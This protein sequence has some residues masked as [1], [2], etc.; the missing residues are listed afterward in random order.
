M[1][2][3]DARVLILGGGGL[4]T[5]LA[6]F[7]ARAGVDVTLFVKP[8]QAAGFEKP[9]V[10]IAGLAEFTA[11]VR[12][13]ANAA[14]LGACDYL[15]VCVKGRDTE[16]ALRPLLDVQVKTVLSLQN[17]VK[18]DETLVRLFG[19]ERVLGARS[20]VG[21]TLQRPGHALHTPSGATLVGELD[22]RT[23]ARGERLAAMI[24]ASGLA[25]A[26]VPDILAHEWH[27]LAAFLPGALICSLTRVDVATTMLDPDLA[28]IRARLAQE[29][30]AVAAA[31]GHPIG[32]MPV[33]VTGAADLQTGGPRIVN[34]ASSEEEIVAEFAAHGQRLRDQGVPLYPSLTHDIL[35][36]RPSEL[37]DT[38]GDVRARAARHGV[39]APTLAVCYQLVRGMERVGFIH[40]GGTEARRE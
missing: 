37:E 10:H 4:G 3:G 23:S 35:A 29:I 33:W 28:R 32:A 2:I 16:A 8:A 31:A 12:V 22:G 5:V 25:A 36:G 6:G 19:A 11:P 34:L 1:G 21:V 24:R 13:A 40:H 39:A 27:K 7:L 30:A 17:G 15:L 26:C 38:A 18:K 9:E 14:E 20:A